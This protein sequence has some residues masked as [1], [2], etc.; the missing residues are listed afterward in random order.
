MSRNKYILYLGLLLMIT[1]VLAFV[2]KIKKLPGQVRSSVRIIP[3]EPK[4][5]EDVAQNELNQ[6]ASI[7]PTRPEILVKFRAG[8]SPDT[9][10]QIT[11][12][13]NDRIQDEIEAVPGLVTIH[14]P[15]NRDAQALL[16]QYSVL[17]EVEYAEPNYEISLDQVVNDPNALPVNDPRFNEQWALSDISLP[18]AWKRTKGSD[19]IVVAVLDSGVEYTH[20]DL[21][22][23]IWTRPATMAPY[24]DPDLGT[25]DDVH[26]YNAVAND[27][28][29]LDDN[30]HGTFCAGIIGAECVNNAG[31]CGVNWKT[32]IM[33]LKFMNAGGFGYVADAVEAIN[34][35]IERKRAGVNLRV[36]N[37]SWGLG[38]PS[39]ALEDII[40]KAHDAGI[41]F[42]AASGSSSS[43]NDTSQRYPAAY[44]VGNIISVAATDQR[45]ALAQFSNYGAKSVHLAAPGKDILTT[46]L[47]NDYEQHSGTSMATA[48]VSGV[49]ALALSAQPGLS[50][51]ELRSLLLRSVDTVPGLRDKVSTGGRINADKATRN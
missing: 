1:L 20:V 37:A 28:D 50:V 18:D 15:D 7:A 14:D 46:T 43:D 51:E 42:V 27:G 21:V 32:Q 9:I 45:D 24:H 10:D 38:Q 19:K 36:I 39:R 30:G 2:V 47:G 48:F 3:E 29:P 13:F 16:A 25:V 40:R 5:R 26:G 35:A 44:G 31:V 6:N 11:N 22:N 8:V 49:A 4:T 12:R 34:Y 23:N 33:P 17:A 41:L